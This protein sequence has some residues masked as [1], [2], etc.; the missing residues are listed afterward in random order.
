[1]ALTYF[2]SLADINLAKEV[3]AKQ[4]DLYIQKREFGGSGVFYTDTGANDALETTCGTTWATDEFTST[5]AN[6]IVIIDDNNK[7]ATGKVDN[8][9]ADHVF[10]DSTAMVLEEDGTTA[11]TLTAGTTYQFRIYSPSSVAGATEGPFFGY[12]EGAELAI[13]DT[14]MK[15]K[16]SRPKQMKFKD[17]EERESQITGGNVNFTNEDVLQTM[18]GAVQYGSQTGQYSYAVGSNPDTDVFYRL[19]FVGEDRSNRVFKIRTREVQFELTGNILS[20]AE[21]GHFMAPFT[22]D[23]IADGFYP[24]DANL[25]QMVRVDE[26]GG[27]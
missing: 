13:N 1:M 8:N 7:V 15:F 4:P 26:A 6:N 18:V 25:L 16:Y 27:C 9:S 24:D 3:I 12:V 14:F 19:T 23:L 21:S 17:L 5:V 2:D 22:A 20:N 11:P 10:F